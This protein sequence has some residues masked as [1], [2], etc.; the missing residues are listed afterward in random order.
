MINLKEHIKLT[1]VY[2]FFA[3]FPA[4]L[5]LIVYPVIE[6]T[7]RLGAQDFGYLA[8]AEA[9]LSFLV[10]FCLNGMAITIA[11]YYYDYCDEKSGYK[12][13]VSTIFS[14][15]II[16]AAVIIALLV[17]FSP[18]IGSFFPKGPLQNFESY[19]I[20]LGIIAFN[21]SVIS[22]ALS[23]YRSEK[24]IRNFI[25]VSLISGLCR[26]LFQIIGVLYFD[27]SFI[28]YLMGTAIGG[29]IA[30]ISILTYTYFN[31]G[32]HFSSTIRKQ[33]R[34]FAL[35]LALTDIMYWGIMFFDRFLL[36][37]NP[38]QLGIYDNAMKFA[39]G[40]LFITQ[41]LAGSVQPEL[42]RLFKKGIKEN[43]K[44]IKSLSNIFVAENILAVG[45]FALPLI[46]FINI[47]YE[48]E[49]LLS[50]G[51]L[52]II[53]VK[54]VFNA[55]FQIFS[56]PILY[57][58]N[59]KLYFL[60]NLITFLV[61]VG[62]NILLVP[63]LGYYGSIISFL[64]AGFV[65]VFAF[66]LAQR[67]IIAIPWNLKKVMLFPITIV[68]FTVIMEYIKIHFELNP[69][70]T[71]IIVVVYI[72]SGLILLYKTDILKILSKIKQRYN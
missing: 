57:N 65:Q 5:Q 53:L 6:G 13:L 1:G 63:S 19:G 7:D 28:G 36:M 69:I 33:L 21:R 39:A 59:S 2:T 40:V 54:F 50:A 41:G 23:L 26:S 27:L 14:G 70:I 68:L 4:L 47:F 11:R 60:L 43:E 52:M 48:T 17:V 66:Y 29:S 32:I 62:L 72:F 10:I 3:V 31:N 16:R 8:I 24:S 42:F 49:L 30:N 38:T 45:V 9:L 67:K 64:A 44:D 56:W 35:P 12:K 20:F 25:S 18:I 34:S 55:Q 37:K 58:K 61:L 51:L 46:L 71:S 15:V 22:V